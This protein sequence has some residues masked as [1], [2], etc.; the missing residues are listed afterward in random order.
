MF[1][2]HRGGTFLLHHDRCH[3]I[4]HQGVP[5]HHHQ[6]DR[7]TAWQEKGTRKGAAGR[8]DG[9]TGAKT[10]CNQ[11]RRFP[12]LLHGNGWNIPAL[13]HSGTDLPGSKRLQTVKV[14]SF[15]QDLERRHALHL[16]PDIH[17]ADSVALFPHFSEV[18]HTDQLGCPSTDKRDHD[19]FGGHNRAVFPWN[20]SG[21]AGD[22]QRSRDAGSGFC[23]E[24]I[25]GLDNP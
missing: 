17:R 7:Q 6:R 1:I 5:V 4:H 21:A 16:L 25:S 19:P 22:P 12:A 20:M 3:A 13:S 2:D 24:I 8:A 23:L 15:P 11:L 14:Q 10:G 9:S 18:L